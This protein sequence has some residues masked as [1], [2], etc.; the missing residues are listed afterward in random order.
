M[1]RS[2]TAS[3]IIFVT[4]AW[5]FLNF[6]PAIMKHVTEMVCVSS[7]LC[8]VVQM[9]LILGYFFIFVLWFPPCCSPMNLIFACFYSF[10]G[11]FTLTLL[12]DKAAC[13]LLGDC[14]G[15]FRTSWMTWHYSDEEMLPVLGQFITVLWL[16]MIAFTMAQARRGTWIQKKSCFVSVLISECMMIRFIQYEKL[17]PTLDVFNQLCLLRF[18]IHYITDQY[19]VES[20]RG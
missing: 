14:L 9:V 19:T 15:Y 3:H 20:M 17:Q 6:M 2:T 5:V 4:H 16:E 8:H 1:V 18:T 7:L 10:C 13:S 11:F 12:E